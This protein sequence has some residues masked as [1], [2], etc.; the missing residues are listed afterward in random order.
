MKTLTLRALATGMLGA[1]LLSG[2]LALADP[3]SGGSTD[4]KTECLAG[5]QDDDNQ[6]VKVCKEHA[7]AGAGQCAAA[8]KEAQRACAKDCQEP[9]DDSK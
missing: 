9:R 2:G 8:C 1:L 4:E 5:C 6:C 3:P 7:G